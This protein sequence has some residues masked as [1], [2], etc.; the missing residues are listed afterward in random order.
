MDK[1]WQR[2]SSSSEDSSYDDTPRTPVRKKVGLNEFVHKKVVA[3]EE[4]DGRSITNTPTR[5]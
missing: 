5:R 3:E 1:Q 2:S 4:V